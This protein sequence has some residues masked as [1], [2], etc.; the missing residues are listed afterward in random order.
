MTEPHEDDYDQG[1]GLILCVEHSS[2]FVASVF[3]S[4]VPFEGLTP[5]DHEAPLSDGEP[6]EVCLR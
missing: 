5:A 1:L 3:K 4:V 2:I 6:P